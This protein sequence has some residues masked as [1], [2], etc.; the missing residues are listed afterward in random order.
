MDYKNCLVSFFDILGFR[1]IINNKDP[2]FISEVLCNLRKHAKPDDFLQSTYEIDSIAFSDN[3]VRSVHIESNANIERPNG[4]LWFELFQLAWLQSQLI[5]EYGVF[6]RGAITVGQLCIQ[7]EI[8]FGPGLVRAYELESKESIYPR[9]LIDD[10]LLDLFRETHPLLGAAHHELEDDQAYINEYAITDSD[11]KRFI[12][13]LSISHI[14]LDDNF[15]EVF[16]VLDRHYKR[17]VEAATN[18]L[19]NERVLEKYRWTA[20]YHNRVV[21]SYPDQAFEAVEVSKKEYLLT[22]DEV[23]GMEGWEIPS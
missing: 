1:E 14:T 6:L 23:P 4:L 19:E 13:Y 3:I 21:E 15:I 7:D 12:N 16:S 17:V 5:F 20:N 18:N 9:I 2:D 10:E 11:G 22:N 8:V